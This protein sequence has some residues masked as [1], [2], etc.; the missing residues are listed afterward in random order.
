MLG[1]IYQ[2]IYLFWRWITFKKRNGTPNFSII[3]NKIYL[4]FRKWFV[5]CASQW[6][7]HEMESTLKHIRW[8][9]RTRL[10]NYNKPYKILI[11]YNIRWQ[12][13]KNI[14]KR[15]GIKLLASGWWTKCLRYKS[16][17][18][19]STY[20]SLNRINDCNSTPAK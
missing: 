20:T 3:C 19:R 11:I 18:L 8:M 7:I 13:R 9:S 10:S 17:K 12:L 5:M 6:Q 15:S 14:D 1:L 4:N 16:S 2:S